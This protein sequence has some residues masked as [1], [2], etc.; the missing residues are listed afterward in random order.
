MASIT[1]RSVINIVCPINLIAEIHQ[2]HCNETG[3]EAHPKK[4]SKAITL[5]KAAA[6]KSY[7]RW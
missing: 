3:D 4:N 5:K 1:G 2:G 6:D 7:C